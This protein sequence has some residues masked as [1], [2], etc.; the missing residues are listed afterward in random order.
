[1][2]RPEA[3]GCLPEF[4]DKMH[5]AGIAPLV[6]ETFSHY[7]RK[8]VKGERG[9]IC[10]LQIE[11]VL[12]ESLQDADHL[13]EYRK[14]GTGALGQTVMI[15]LNGGLGT[16]MGLKRAKSLLEA[17]NGKSFLEITL[18]Q[19][20]RAGVKL[21]LMNSFGT[22]QDTVDAVEKIRP[23]PP[24]IY[25]LQH[26]FP[27]ILRENLAPA[28]WPR[29]PG[30]EWNPPGHGDVYAALHTSGTLQKLLDEGMRYAFITNSD[31]LGGALNTGLLGYFSSRQFP[32]MMEVAQ[33]SAS[34]T[35]GG[36]LAR[37]RSDRLVLREIAQCPEQDLDRFQDISYH[38]YFNTNNIWIHLDFLNALIQRDRV[39]RLP[40]IVNPK[41]LDPR[42]ETS[43]P[44]YQIETAMGSAI[45]L[46]PGA[47]AVKVPRDRLLP[48]KTCN[49]LLA[50]R[51]D[52]YILTEN[53]Q[54][55]MNP[56]VT[57][58]ETRISLDSCYYKRID[59]FE[60][61]FPAGVP[62]LKHCSAL[63]IEG[64]VRFEKNVVVKGRVCIRNTGHRP[65]V[66]PAG[67]VL[68]TDLFFP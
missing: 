48:V 58:P 26:K 46:F 28:V 49:D 60:A 53:G 37:L 52:R 57:T 66:I 23:E 59:Q 42:D 10:D 65:V 5:Q 64:D 44:V 38:R 11:P 3:I 15:V 56:G 55:K 27:K 40:M 18:A 6:V 16:S 62:S 50:V 9:K 13:D 39:V 19:A 67:A 47:A 33:R 34:D 32:F 20:A 22:H 36:H 21:C 61:R 54:L 35:K 43:P 14:A 7:Y 4:V 2:N 24:P 1:M 17:K 63:T 41:S 51:S 45:S 68:E 12:P 8:I 31:N 29:N 25:F 30:L